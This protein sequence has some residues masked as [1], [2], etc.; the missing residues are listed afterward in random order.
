MVLVLLGRFVDGITEQ[1]RDA[2]RPF[3]QGGLVK[4]AV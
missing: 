4:E 3:L 2:K 1:R